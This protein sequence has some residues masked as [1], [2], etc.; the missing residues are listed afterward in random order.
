MARRQES[1][2]KRER[3]WETE[4]YC[5]PKKTKEGN[6]RK[7]W[8]TQNGQRAGIYPAIVLAHCFGCVVLKFHSCQLCFPQHQKVRK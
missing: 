6:D 2:R 4:I 1:G 7:R 8:R 3:K 5:R